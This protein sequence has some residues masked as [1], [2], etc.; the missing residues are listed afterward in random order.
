MSASSMDVSDLL[1]VGAD[2]LEDTLADHFK[3]HAAQAGLPA[4]AAPYTRRP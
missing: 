1:G 4:E 3:E 2:D